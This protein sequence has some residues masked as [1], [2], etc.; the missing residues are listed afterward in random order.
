VGAQTLKA[1]VVRL[2]S[3]VVMVTGWVRVGCARLC[4]V[5]KSSLRAGL[6]EMC[7][8]RG[9]ISHYL[10]TTLYYNNLQTSTNMLRYLL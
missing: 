1:G 5:H 6:R 4:G 8:L 2:Y 7:R 9:A 3:V 10:P